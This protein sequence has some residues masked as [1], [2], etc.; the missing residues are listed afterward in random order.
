MPTSSPQWFAYQ[1][2]INA[3]SQPLRLKINTRNL[4]A[5]RQPSARRQ[6]Q[7]CIINQIYFRQETNAQHNVG[8]MCV[9]QSFQKITTLEPS[10]DH[11]RHETSSSQLRQFSITLNLTCAH[12]YK[13]VWWCVCIRHIVHILSSQKGS[14]SM[15]SCKMLKAKT[16][17][18]Y[19]AY[20]QMVPVECH[21]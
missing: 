17:A 13:H 21:S 5:W 4:L 18:Q 7:S 14:A 8:I 6:K 15:T 2:N 16:W 10:C 3:Q 12:F 9:T 20:L 11:Y 19:T 1:L